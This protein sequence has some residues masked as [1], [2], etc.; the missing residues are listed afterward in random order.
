MIV[1][2]KRL[3]VKIRHAI[4]NNNFDQNNFYHLI[5]HIIVKSL[6]SLFDYFLI[7]LS[8]CQQVGGKMGTP[9]PDRIP[10]G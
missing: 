8:A 6:V 4:I 2:N 1:P 7:I 5:K 10:G 3:P 9:M